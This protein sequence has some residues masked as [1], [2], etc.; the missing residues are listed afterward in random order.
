MSNPRNAHQSDEQAALPSTNRGSHQCVGF[1][2][3][4]VPPAIAGSRISGRESIGFTDRG[5]ATASVV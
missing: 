5:T 2:V 3:V 1:A 4:A